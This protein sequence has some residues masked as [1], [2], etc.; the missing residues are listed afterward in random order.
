MMRLWQKRLTAVSSNEP[1]GVT[2]AD[3]VRQVWAIGSRVLVL[4]LRFWEMMLGSG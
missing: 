4:L 3:I 2:Q 1:H